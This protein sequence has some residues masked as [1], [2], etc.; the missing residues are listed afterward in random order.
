M[1]EQYDQINHAVPTP[2]LVLWM[3][4][5]EAG[6]LAAWNREAFD[7]YAAACIAENAST[8]SWQPIETAPKDDTLVD[9]WRPWIHSNG[10]VY[11]GERCTDMRRV[12]L[13]P[14]NIFYSPDYSG[15]SCVRD[16]THWMLAPEPPK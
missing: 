7:A 12:E 16:A 11:G 15:P 13:A 1:I 6:W 4:E 9:L 8:N 5:T 3:V 2:C 14:D 10:R